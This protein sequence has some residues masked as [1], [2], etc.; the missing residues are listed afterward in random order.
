M[1]FPTT[2]RKRTRPIAAAVALAL[3]AGAFGDAFAADP[4]DKS[5]NEAAQEKHV[6]RMKKA[7]Q[8]KA[9]QAR[10]R[11]LPKLQQVRADAAKQ[12][13]QA[14]A[15]Q[16]GPSRAVDMERINAPAKPRGVAP[17]ANAQVSIRAGQSVMASHGWSEYQRMLKR[18]QK[19]LTPVL[20][21]RRGHDG[22]APA[23]SEA[24]TRSFEIPAQHIGGANGAGQ[25]ARFGDGGFAGRQRMAAGPAGAP[26]RLQAVAQAL[27]PEP[28]PARD[29]AMTLA[30]GAF[31]YGAIAQTERATIDENVKAIVRDRRAERSL[32]DYWNEDLGFDSHVITLFHD[33]DGRPEVALLKGTINMARRYVPNGNLTNVLRFKRGIA[34]S[35]LPDR[36]QI[37]FVVLSIDGKPGYYRVVYP[38]FP[39]VVGGVAEMCFV[40]LNENGEEK[41]TSA[42]EAGLPDDLDPQ[43]LPGKVAY[44]VYRSLV[45][46]E[47]ADSRASSLQAA[48]PERLPEPISGR[49]AA[50]VLALGA[51][52]YDAIARTERNATNRN[53]KA[54]VRDESAEGSLDDIW[55]LDLAFDS[56]DIILV[57]DDDGRPNIERLSEFINIARGYVPNGKSTN[58]LHFNGEIAYGDLPDRDQI[59]FVV[60]SIDGKPGYTVVYPD[61]HRDVGGGVE[62]VMGFA[63]LNENGERQFTSAAEAGLPDLD[64]QALPG[65]V[66]YVVYRPRAGAEQ[67]AGSR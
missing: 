62:A 59:A 35:Y 64:P 30:F 33:D 39:R 18:Q 25:D 42:A 55:N 14:A 53:V 16:K 24:S 49:D 45:G 47:P 12:P 22:V 67:A 15:P 29:A 7:R 44:V 28:I 8:H 56:T 60:L 36:D 50:V 23:H 27:L 61:F 65:K 11:A 48:D 40:S 1:T 46:A 51:I 32:D 63:S 37:A 21:A 34:Y 54:I 38:S 66:A 13:A 58:V 10:P 5:R 4:R 57:V 20:D 6:E 9:A 41:F 52:D 26:P 43:A 3:L 2:L 31:D 17:R 19:L